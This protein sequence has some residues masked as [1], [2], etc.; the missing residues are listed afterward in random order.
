MTA[1][2]KEKGRTVVSLAT[3]GFCQA[4][5]PDPI[6]RPAG[7]W[8]SPC[9]VGLYPLTGGGGVGGGLL[10][11]QGEAEGL[12]GSAPS[13]LLPPVSLPQC[14]TRAEPAGQRVGLAP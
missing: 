11:L 4:R 3:C 10:P 7:V 13:L 12:E 8:L 14:S 9:W 6:P 2:W 5:Y 1:T